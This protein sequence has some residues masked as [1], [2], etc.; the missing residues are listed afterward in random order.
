M[1][2]TMTRWDTCVH[3]DKNAVHE[4]ANARTKKNWKQQ[5]KK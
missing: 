5:Q 2:Q 3:N 4:T 1:H